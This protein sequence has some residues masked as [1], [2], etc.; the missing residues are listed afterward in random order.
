MLVVFSIQKTQTPPFNSTEARSTHHT[1]KKPEHF[2]LVS[3]AEPVL[4]NKKGNLTTVD[5][6]WKIHIYREENIT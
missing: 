2:V 5:Y 1:H 4:S 6:M 3:A